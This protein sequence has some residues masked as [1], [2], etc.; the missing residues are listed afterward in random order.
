ML[1]KL[2]HPTEYISDRLFK[3]YLQ[4]SMENINASAKG[5]AYDHKK[6]VVLSNFLKR[7][8]LNVDL[9]FFASGKALEATVN[10]RFKS[11]TNKQWQ[12]ISNAYGISD[13]NAFIS[14]VTDYY[15]LTNDIKRALF[16][17]I[18]LGLC[19]VTSSHVF[20][21]YNQYDILKDVRDSNGI[22]IEIDIYK[23]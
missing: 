10:L 16:L 5:I 23:I 8:D 15:S 13:T 18:V 22:N 9:G 2:T 4:S 17:C 20:E 6:T 3:N 7:L 14:Q 12:D 19:T 1:L 11:L 21:L